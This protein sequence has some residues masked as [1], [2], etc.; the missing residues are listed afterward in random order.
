MT[1]TT[2][3]VYSGTAVFSPYLEF[4]AV[5]R[6]TPS[7]ISPLAYHLAFVRNCDQLRTCPGELYK[8]GS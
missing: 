8:K 2:W 5:F 6:Q 4:R 3:A 1:A 7:S